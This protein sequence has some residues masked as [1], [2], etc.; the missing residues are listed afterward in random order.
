M[1]SIS[2]VRRGNYLSKPYAD[3]LA[4]DRVDIILSN[5][6][7]GGVEEDGTETNF[8]TKFRTKETADLFLALII[9]LLKQ[10]GVQRLSYQMG[11]FLVKV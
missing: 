3:W 10:M 7:F 11:H 1:D 5:P 4:N 6:P 8:P 9:R 2:A